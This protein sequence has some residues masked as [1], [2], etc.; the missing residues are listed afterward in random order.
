M[1]NTAKLELGYYKKPYALNKQGLSR[2]TASIAGLISSYTAEGNDCVMGY[3]S[4]GRKTGTSRSTIARA[5]KKLKEAGRITCERM[6]THSIYQFIPSDD[7][8]LSTYMRVECWLYHKKFNI[9]GVERYL[10]EATVDVYS[11]IYTHASNKKNLSGEF[12]GSVTTISK[13]LQ[14]SRTT[15]SKSINILLSAELIY[16]EKSHQGRKLSKFTV[17]RKFVREIERQQRKMQKALS[18][19]PE[20]Q[21]IANINERTDVERWYASRRAQAEAVVDRNEKRAFENP[22]YKAVSIELS[23]ANR[24]AAKADAF[25]LGTLPDLLKYVKELEVKRL[26]VL[27]GMGMTE[28]DFIPQYHCKKCS[29]TGFLSNGKACDCYKR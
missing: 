16:R 9:H 11:L 15:A 18:T 27:K 22:E 5:I 26:N 4:I 17:N 20:Q 25:G 24:E 8:D 13:I 3:K 2:G 12:I 10:T 28:Q 19:S 14:M 21:R 29:D 1:E 6:K 7:V 23:T